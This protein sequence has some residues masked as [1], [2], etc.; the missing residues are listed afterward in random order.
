MKERQPYFDDLFAV[1][2]VNHPDQ[3]TVVSGRH[4]AYYAAR[5]HRTTHKCWADA[6][7]VT[8]TQES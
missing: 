7:S 1:E 2:C 8:P 6:V 3:N 5:V 4:N